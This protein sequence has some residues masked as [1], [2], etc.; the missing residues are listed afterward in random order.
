MVKKFEINKHLDN[1]ERI[2]VK[3]LEE[4]E[5]QSKERIKRVIS[6]VKENE[7]I[8]SQCQTNFLSIKQYAS[9]LQTFLGITE[10]EMKVYENEQYLHSL[11]ED[12]SLKQVELVWKEDPAMH[13]ILSSL[14]NF[15][16]IELKTQ[17]SN[18]EFTGAKDKQAQ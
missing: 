9:D 13:C 11:V 6:F 10:I 4:K 8:I 12:K 2:I 7:T 18:I 3:D 16:S 14:R 17:T 1:L 15:G 5:C